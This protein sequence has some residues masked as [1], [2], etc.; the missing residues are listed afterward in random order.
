LAFSVASAAGGVVRLF[1]ND[2]LKDLDRLANMADPLYLAAESI[3]NLAAGIGE[4]GNVLS[5][6]DLAGL[7][8]IREVGKVSMERDLTEQITNRFDMP[9]MS[10]PD[11][12][13]KVV[14]FEFITLKPA[15]PRREA[16][17]QNVRIVESVNQ[18]IP[19]NEAKRVP[20]TP[21]AAMEMAGGV[22]GD[23]YVGSSGV[24]TKRI[25]FLLE[26]VKKLLE[27]IYRTP[28]DV[29]MDGYKVN[30]IIKSNNQ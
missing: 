16:V 27:A 29:K 9:P 14:P 30:K 24:S 4:L 28:S 1:G 22:G 12:D 5:S 23:T 26:D 21:V 15:P 7:A 25:E 3:R 17:A 2:V 20:A 19:D 11:S 6:V 8:E 18:S 10:A 13:A